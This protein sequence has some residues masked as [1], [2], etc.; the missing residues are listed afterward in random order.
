VRS[1]TFTLP[2][3][4]IVVVIGVLLVRPNCGSSGRAKEERG[5]VSWVVS[6]APP[7]TIEKQQRWRIKRDLTRRIMNERI[8]LLEAAELFREAN[9]EDGMY[10]LT[11]SNPNRSLRE[12]LCRQVID[13]V[14]T[15]ER[16][17]EC[18]GRVCSGTRLSEELQHELDQ[19]IAAG[20]FPPASG[21]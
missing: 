9:G 13:Y 15:V 10:S 14:V 5:R 19:R 12:L 8:S 6:P 17:W 21:R 7:E 18:E 1:V 11:L 3:A 4:I 16:E 2:T 20:E